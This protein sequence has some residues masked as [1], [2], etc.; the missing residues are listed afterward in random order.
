MKVRL[1]SEELKH[2]P[3]SEHWTRFFGAVEPGEHS[4]VGSYLKETLLR[5]VSELIHRPHKCIR[6]KLVEIGFQLAQEIES[7]AGRTGASAGNSSGHLGAR[8]VEG[9]GT[10]VPGALSVLGAAIEYLH[11]GSLIVDDIQDGSMHRRGGPTIHR[12][13]GTPQAIAAGNWMYF[14][15]MTL[16]RKLEVADECKQLLYEV[17]HDATLKA[18]EGQSL[19]VSLRVSDLPQGDVA[20]LSGAVMDLKTGSLTALG[21][22]LGA[23]VGGLRGKELEALVTFGRRFGVAL[24]MFD[25]IGN[26]ASQNDPEKRMEDLLNR[27]ISFVWGFA[28]KQ[29]SVEQ[30]QEFL[31]LVNQLP[32]AEPM[33]NFLLQYEFVSR[34]KREAAELLEDSFAKL[35]SVWPALSTKNLA[36]G[37]L[38]SLGEILNHAF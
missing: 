28:A 6:A 31:E 19:D 2:L 29:M 18:H 15:P 21:L 33:Q 12:I 13:F 27:R 34:A 3:C 30:Y 11:G 35:L 36:L 17:F 9:T 8:P 37:Q 1:V 23:I 25:D 22:A 16:I 24:Q 14:Y 10:A 20:R 5:P 4:L 26:L 38:Q 7:S 32:E